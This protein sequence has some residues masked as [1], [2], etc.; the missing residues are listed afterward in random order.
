M[1]A[2]TIMIVED[3]VVFAMELEEKLDQM[4]YT[5]SDVVSSGEGALSKI[6]GTQPDL[7]LMDIRLDGDLDGIQAAEQIRSLHHIPVVYV[8]AHSDETTLNRAK[9]TEP[10]GYLVKPITEKDLRI[11]V[12]M[13]LYKAKMERRLRESEAR[14]KAMFETAEDWVFVKDAQLRYTHVNPSML[15]FFGISS[16]QIIGKSDA[17]LMGPEEA[18]LIRETE[19]RVLAGQTVESEQG[20]TLKGVKS[21]WDFVRAPIRDGAGLING[22]CGIGRDVTDRQGREWDAGGD[23]DPVRSD[24]YPSPAMRHTLSQVRLAAKTDST[25]LMLGD[26]GSGKDFLAKYLHDNSSRVNGPFINV[27]CAAIPAEL[28]ESELFGHEA[29]A[30]TGSSRRKRGLLELAEGGTLL[31]NE[32]GELSPQLQAKLLTFLD[33]H[34]FTRVGGER[35][36]SV[37]TRLVAATNTDL[38]KEVETGKFRKDLFYRLNVVTI[39]VPPLRE[40]KE[41]IP[42]L[43]DSLLRSLHKKLGLRRLPSVQADAMETLKDYHWPGN[44]R[45]L[46][47]VLERALI[48][49]DGRTVNAGHIALD[50]GPAIDISGGDISFTLRVSKQSTINDAVRD[51]KKFVVVEGLRR[52]GGNVKEA[53]KLLGISRDAMNYLLKSLDIQRP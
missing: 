41:D 6:N 10:V 52:S 27:N 2:E 32:I 48:H 43:V 5:V 21:V 4:G 24:E 53:A 1:P 39:R 18:R 8:T 26:S 50:A 47:N 11:T 40:R 38:E 22:L 29:G 7:V 20:V 14:F 36:I 31:L 3:E 13:A 51:A 19:S 49:S 23:V 12:E 45:E 17:E 9:I 25:V 16:S 34:S 15:S 42:A 28:A 37:N 33:T 44:V 30:F 35:S 46:R